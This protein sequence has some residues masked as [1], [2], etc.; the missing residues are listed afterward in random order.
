MDNFA[1]I[2][3]RRIDDLTNQPNKRSWSELKTLLEEIYL[4]ESVLRE[5][6]KKTKDQ[7]N[8]DE[9]KMEKKM[10]EHQIFY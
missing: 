5:E 1:N 7:K 3:K 4:L 10:E 2:I 9:E 8:K 6:K